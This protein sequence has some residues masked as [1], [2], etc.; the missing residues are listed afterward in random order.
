MP[1]PA[2]PSP[3]SG[4]RDD[5]GSVDDTVAAAIADRL[6]DAYHTGRPVAPIRDEL[7]AGG[8]PAA[9]RVQEL[10]VE[11]WEREGR[12]VVGRKIGLTSR[13]VQQQLGVDQPDF[14]ALTADMCLTSGESIPTAAILQPKVEAE[15]ALVLASDLDQPDSTVA[16]LIAAIDFVVPAIEVVGSRIADWDIGIL[17]T[18]ADNASSGMFVL[19]TRPVAPGEVDLAEVRMELRVDGTVASTGTGAAC[20]GHPYIAALWLARRSYEVGRPLRAGDVVLT[21]SLG[22]LVPLE[23]GA[24]VDM[25]IT[26]L[27]S[28]RTARDH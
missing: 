18:I 3:S 1:D 20:L 25:S 27:G 11:R 23:P 2:A 5:A 14:G 26:G 16:E 17:G 4:G 21:G 15:V 8:I 12:R 22:P 19:G 6:A 13:A 9:Y 28:V 10:T 7:A 24:E